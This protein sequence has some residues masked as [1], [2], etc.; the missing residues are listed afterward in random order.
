M[1]LRDSSYSPTRLHWLLLVPLL[2]IDAPTAL[3]AAAWPQ[4]SLRMVVPFAPGGAADVFARVLAQRL[5]VSLKQNV[6]VDNRAGA[7]GFLGTDL[8]AKAEP[9]GYTLL[10]TA[11]STLTIG[12]NLYKTVP[13]DPLKDLT[14]VDKAVTTVSM[15][16]THPRIKANSVAALIALAKSQKVP[17]TFASSGSGAIGHLAGELFKAMAGVEITHIPYRGGG[18]A[19]N[20]L[21]GGET[22]MSFATYPSAIQHVKSGRL[23]LLAVSNH[24]RSKLLPDTPTIAESGVPGFGADM[25][26]GLLGP[27]R[28]G[29]DIVARLDGAVTA[30]LRLKEFNDVLATQG[31]EADRLGPTEFRTYLQSDSARWKQLIEQYGIRAD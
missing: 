24:N 10:F 21:I 19:I 17:L 9:D 12:P 28:M 1:R 29:R 11:N 26:L 15:L 14:P 31:A 8:V 5:R 23:K 27:A 2:L 6:I 13:Y 25:W 7:G 4:K 18:P 20:A 30:I 3:G 16:V 22:D